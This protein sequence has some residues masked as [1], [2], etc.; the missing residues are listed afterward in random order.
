MFLNNFLYTLLGT[1][2][3]MNTETITLKKETAQELMLLIN[4]LIEGK[5]PYYKKQIHALKVLESKLV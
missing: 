2:K 1:F 3:I 4:N 5:K